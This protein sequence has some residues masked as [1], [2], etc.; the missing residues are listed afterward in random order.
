MITVFTPMIL[1]NDNGMLAADSSTS[2]RTLVLGA[3]LALYPLGQFFGAPIV[4]SLSDRFG[5]KRVLLVSLV[6]STAAT[7]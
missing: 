5:R 3:L 2:E 6:A 1:G 4:G 7:A